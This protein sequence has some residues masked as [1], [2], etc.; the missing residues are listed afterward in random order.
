MNT[1]HGKTILVTGATGLIGSSLVYALMKMGEINVIALSRNEQKLKRAFSPLID[2]SGF[3]YITQD[4]SEPIQISTQIDVIFHAASPI[5]GKTIVEKPIDVIKPNLMA[6]QNL[7]ELLRQQKAKTGINGRIVI[8]SSAT[9]YGNNTSLDI[10]VTENDTCIADSLES[11]SAPYSE[12]KRMAE[13]LARA[14]IKQY[15]VDA[16]I[17]RP[18]YVYGNTLFPPETAIYEFIEKAVAG[19]DIVLR[20]SGASKR[21]NIFIDDVVSG[22]FTILLKGET[23]Q[24][25]NI[26]TAGELESF[27]A[28]DEIA[29]LIADITNE[30]MKSSI[31]VVYQMSKTDT[32]KPGV[33]L[34][35]NKLKSLGWKPLVGLKDGLNIMITPN[36]LNKN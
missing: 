31:H 23:G 17:A 30:K 20:N 28:I 1:L 18:S 26:S 6:T 29:G 35:N 34:D 36:R 19:E 13:V 16:V 2:K 21:D 7:L 12:S 25:Y 14:Y 11:S 3:A 24:A 15:G 32:R 5:A 10:K 8:F 27:A 4:I 9:V 22:L 33:M